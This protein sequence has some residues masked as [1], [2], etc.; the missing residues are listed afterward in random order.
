MS[1]VK[2]ID[3]SEYIGKIQQEKTPADA[4]SVYYEAFPDQKDKLEEARKIVGDEEFLNILKA[5]I[6]NKQV[7]AGFYDRKSERER[8]AEEEAIRQ[9]NAE[10]AE[11]SMLGYVGEMQYQETLG[12][13]KGIEAGAKRV[14]QAWED[15]IGA[16]A[17]KL[18]ETVTQPLV[19]KARSAL[20]G[21][22]KVEDVRTVLETGK[23]PDSMMPSI[24]VMGISADNA[25]NP[26][27]VLG[28]LVKQGM[29]PDVTEIGEES[30]QQMILS[31]SVGKS[32]D[33]YTRM[34]F[35]MF[36]DP[37]ASAV[38][39]GEEPA[40]YRSRTELA[41]EHPM[42][43]IPALSGEAVMEYPVELIEH[44]D[45]MAKVAAQ[46]LVG[47]FIVAPIV[48]KGI[49][50]AIARSPLAK[51]VF[52]MDMGQAYRRWLKMKNMKSSPEAVY[53]FFQNAQRPD[54]AQQVVVRGV[55]KDSP[56][57]LYTLNK[58]SNRVGQM[59]AQEARAFVEQ[60]ARP[61]RNGQFKVLVPRSIVGKVSLAPELSAIPEA[62]VGVPPTVTVP[63][64][65]P[66]QV[67]LLLESPDVIPRMPA[68]APVGAM[69][70][71]TTVYP[72]EAMYAINADPTAANTGY[73]VDEVIFMRSMGM[74]DP[75]IK[76]RSLEELKPP[77]MA[78]FRSEAISKGD[79]V[80]M[81]K[82]K[83]AGKVIDDSDPQ[84]LMV[85]MRNGL[86]IKVAREEVLNVEYA[87]IPTRVVPIGQMPIMEVPKGYQSHPAII[88]AD[89]EFLPG[90]PMQSTVEEI[91]KEP[92]AIALPERG[93][94]A[95]PEEQPP[96]APVEQPPLPQPEQVAPPVEQ[97]PAKPQVAPTPAEKPTR[98]G[99]RREIKE[100]QKLT[101]QMAR[102]LGI[103]VPSDSPEAA[104]SKSRAEVVVETKKELTELQKQIDNLK[105]EEGF[106][107]IPSV[108]EIKAAARRVV[109]S[110]SQKF[111]FRRQKK[112]IEFDSLI[113]QLDGMRN[114][115]AI[116]AKFQGDNMRKMGSPKENNELI[117]RYMDQPDKYA[118]DFAKLPKE[119]RALA[120]LLQELYAQLGAAAQKL[121][122]LDQLRENYILHSWEEKPEAIGK[123]FGVGTGKLHDKPSFAM[124]RKF[125]TFDDGEE[126]GLTPIL[127]PIKLY[128]L[129][130][131]EFHRAAAD[132]QF[133][134]AVRQMVDENGNPLIMGQPKDPA[135]KAI[136]DNEYV[137]LNLPSINKLMSEGQVPAK[138]HPA[139]APSITGYFQQQW[140]VPSF[141]WLGREIDLW[142]K[143]KGFR[144]FIKRIHFWNPLVHG[145]NVM[146]NNIL[147]SVISS[148]NPLKWA[149]KPMTMFFK[150][151]KLWESHDQLVLDMAEAGLQ[152]AHARN[153][154]R[155]M[156]EEVQNL[157][158]DW[159]VKNVARHPYAALK[160]FNDVVLWE[161]MVRNSQL[162]AADMLRKIM[163][164]RMPDTDQK[165]IDKTIAHHLNDV[166]G[167]LP[168]YWMSR[169]SRELGA[170]AFLARN[171]T[172][173][174]INLPVKA[175]T[176][177]RAGAGARFAPEETKKQLGRLY[178]E[179]VGGM[180]LLGLVSINLIQY[181]CIKATNKL[182]KEGKMNGALVEPHL[183]F[184][185]GW[186]R[187]LDVDTGFR[188]ARGQPL[189]VIPGLFRNIRDWRGWL[190]EP[191]KV[192]MNKLEPFLKHN[193]E[194]LANYSTWK[195][196]DIVPQ[197]TPIHKALEKRL[198]YFSNS[199]SPL[200]TF[201]PEAGKVKHK[202]EYIM[203]F[204][205]QWISKGAPG[206]RL[207]EIYYDT[208]DK[209]KLEKAEADAEIDELIQKGE[210]QA[211]IEKMLTVGRYKTTKGMADRIKKFVAP[212][213]YM[214][215]NATKEELMA[216]VGELKKHG[217]TIKDLENAA[218]KEAM[219][220][221]GRH[222]IETNPP[223]GEDA[224]RPEGG[225]RGSK[226]RRPAKTSEFVVPD[227]WLQQAR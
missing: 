53:E 101:K 154:A 50:T 204:T 184:Q 158:P 76:A 89:D 35:K 19:Q 72:T 146:S 133:I 33:A 203:P 34:L 166:Y 59:S 97:P 191:T 43:S 87:D 15:V 42:R 189:Y 179:F 92:E 93:A 183:T 54:V 31:K 129:Y 206:G 66:R 125:N 61:I 135:K 153:I 226:I 220:L 7:S 174:N 215:Q 69:G 225:Y 16:P 60:F 180:L 162:A 198:E 163:A 224:E 118:A 121:G 202:L 13:S 68:G 137:Y 26:K 223:E 165:T 175:M 52:T 196:E 73:S 63:T 173:S 205:G 148:K 181:A 58:L 177:G 127:D 21:G 47:K 212:L 46:L 201:A 117:S 176:L 100:I 147:M 78:W 142:S 172:I 214:L 185:N 108:T 143:Y 136:Y 168:A 5:E 141:Q 24:G 80:I 94:I 122:F 4:I 195:H 130:A 138:I 194:Q 126:A 161:D 139:I 182:K 106:I 49:E 111:D 115:G 209:M 134:D 23:V 45:Q 85:Q 221:L 3:V 103:D 62:A 8:I 112:Q 123:A 178:G 197:G 18:G 193:I 84:M 82:W 207:A 145:W 64:P 36:Y 132:K 41:A 159:S 79:A 39:K 30:L 102:D 208:K 156:Q 216:Y 65:T 199:M 109:D 27:V 96:V 14:E 6:R 95:L 2:E 88:D 116:Y 217:Y 48:G 17:R 120:T 188:N 150:G 40:G 213:N 86:K 105:G 128:E 222:Y 98:A 140:Q 20:A 167:T 28:E 22:V 114:K 83:T 227:E 37:Y 25:R 1:E 200:S 81:P 74:T 131:Y 210:W 169:M 187:A 110:V 160:H 149:T 55:P 157:V 155:Q 152:V 144:G 192:A 104:I 10:R 77:D 38:R 186:R 75:Q 218:V 12:L 164:K 29:M 119:S 71:P 170:V 124:P 91:P 67:P 44:P 32:R 219:I 9:R 99:L 56:E 51:R 90:R 70:I 113:A 211:T 57:V 107:Y 190:T 11:K 151:K 171:W